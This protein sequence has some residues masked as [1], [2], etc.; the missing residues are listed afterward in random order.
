MLLYSG[1]VVVVDACSMIHLA[2]TEISV[3]R[4]YLSRETHQMKLTVDWPY[5]TILS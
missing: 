3:G 1:V 4:H 5:L 2:V